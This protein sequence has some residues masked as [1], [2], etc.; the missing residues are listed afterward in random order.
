MIRKGKIMVDIVMLIIF[1]VMMGYHIFVDKAHE[2][3]G[4]SL[5]ML[6]TVHL[7]F[8]R[9]WFLGFHRGKYSYQRYL[10][11]FINVLSIAS[12]MLTM[13]SGILMSKHILQ[14]IEVENI[15]LI[16]K[17]HMFGSTWTYMLISMHVG[18]HLTWI[19]NKIFKNSNLKNIT[20][21]VCTG[22]FLY[23]CSIFVQRK[24]FDDMFLRN[25]FKF[26]P[27]GENIIHFIIAYA[28]V[29]VVGAVIGNTLL[30]QEKYRAKV[31][32]YVSNRI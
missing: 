19:T 13:I 24:F 30:H 8:N 25:D 27:F 18:L 1:M 23:G 11:L 29:M 4:I 12:F 14:S 7:V 15:M 3:I 10:I 32:T 26:L 6:L 9:K 22:L 28:A 17:L 16:R 31:K 5:L 20:K 21:V 2:W